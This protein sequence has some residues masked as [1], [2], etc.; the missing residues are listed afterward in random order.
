MSR[1]KTMGE[2]LTPKRCC[3]GRDCKNW[4]RLTDRNATECT[5]CN[6]NLVPIYTYRRGKSTQS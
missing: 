4:A 6:G 3:V 5:R 2:C 1:A